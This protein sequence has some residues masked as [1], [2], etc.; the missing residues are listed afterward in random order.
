MFN[1]G[2]YP[3]YNY[4]NNLNTLTKLKKINWSGFLDGTQKTL[5]IINQA[6]PIFY[7]IKPL[8]DNA[9]TAFKVVNA[10]KKDDEQVNI[11]KKDNIKESKKV[12]PI[13]KSNSP[14]YFL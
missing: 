11:V 14:T 3:Y 6:I 2:Y 5:G 1:N 4:G 13:N 8:Y 10:I 9:K 12:E 7:Q